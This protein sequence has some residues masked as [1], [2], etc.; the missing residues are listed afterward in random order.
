[1]LHRTPGYYNVVRPLRDGVIADLGMTELMI[2]HFMEKVLHHRRF[3]SPRI[4]IGVP[5][6]ITDV[7]K[8]AV[9]ECAERAG[10]R[11]IRVIHES[12]A[13]A[14]GAK[15]PI[16]EPEGNM[17]CD[18]GG[19][20]TEI[21]VLSLGGTVISNAIRVGGDEFDEAII[22]KIRN[23]NNITIKQP[24]AEKIKMTIGTLDLKGKVETM[25]I[26][27]R[28]ALTGLPKRLE[29]N[30]KEIASAL[31]E[32]FNIILDEVKKTLS[33]TPDE[34]VS[35]IIERGIVLA[36]GGALLKGINVKIAEGTGV[37]VIITD[38]PLRCVADG[39][40]KYFEHEKKLKT[41]FQH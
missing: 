16:Y 22:R 7:E 10:A 20:T 25:E 40:G 15:L 30:S 5:S 32:P 4:T 39:A 36:G 6:C 14:L 28:D 38:D 19:G 1:M 12:L 3:V 33:Q 21:S 31:M 35:D 34:L 26:R 9:V 8:R 27:G 13:A 24:T 37:P 11:Q 23:E 2:R 29:I 41:L 18:I 17:I